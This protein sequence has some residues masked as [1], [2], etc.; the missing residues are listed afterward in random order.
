MMTAF[1]LEYR[2]PHYNG[3]FLT[4]INGDTEDAAL[5]GFVSGCADDD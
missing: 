3:T 2:D 1:L 5:E 4:E